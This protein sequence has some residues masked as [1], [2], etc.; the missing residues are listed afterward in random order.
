[1]LAKVAELSPTTVKRI[2]D[3]VTKSPG[4]IYVRKLAAALEVSTDALLSDDPPPLP[5][6]IDH[7]AARPPI[8][9]ELPMRGISSGGTWMESEE[10]KEKY[11]VVRHAA[12][13]GRF[14]VRL[15]GDSMYPDL[16]S[17]DLL[18]FEPADRVP[19]GKIAVVR[20]EATGETTVK[21]VVKQKGGGL[22]LKGINPTF[23]PMET[24]PGEA[25]VIAR[26]LRIVEGER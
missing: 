3:G 7:D 22:L 1:M 17:G 8:F 20:K 9:E 25:K 19:D 16:R 21:C 15:S 14:I 26:F 6:G 10:L 23:K 2:E 12:K 13:P 5:P 18:L 4:P 24:Q 11:P